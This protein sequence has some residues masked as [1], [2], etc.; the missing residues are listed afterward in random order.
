MSQD[1]LRKGG[2][3]KDV[4]ITLRNTAFCVSF[5]ENLNAHY[6]LRIQRDSIQ[7]DLQK[8]NLSV[9][10]HKSQGNLFHSSDWQNQ[11]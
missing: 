4:M 1:I 9:A 10:K 2:K 8:N 5:P 11:K 6:I 3:K 7:I